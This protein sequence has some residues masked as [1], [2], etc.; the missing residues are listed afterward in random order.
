[1][2]KKCDNWKKCQYNRSQK[3]KF[4]RVVKKEIEKDYLKRKA[5]ILDKDEV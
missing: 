5:P 4:Q 3:M 2:C 1:M